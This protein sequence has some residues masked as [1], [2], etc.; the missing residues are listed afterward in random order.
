MSAVLTRR[1]FLASALAG[2]AAATFGRRAWGVSVSISPRP[3][4]ATPRRVAIVGAGL[5]GLTAALD[6]SDAGWDVVVLEARPRVGGRVHTLY[7]PFSTG[8]HAEAGG[9]S[10]DDNHDQIQ[11]LVARFGLRTERRPPDKLLDARVYYRRKR[12][13]LREF[14]G[15]RQGAV[16]L[17]YLRFSDALATLSQDIDP[18][19]PER[20]PNADELD[21]RTLDDFIRSQHLVPE[22]EFLVRLQNRASYNAEPSHLSLLFVAQQTVV[23]ADVP[24]SASETMRIS[25]GNSRLPEAMARALGPRVRLNSPVTRVEH[26]PDGVRV[27]AGGR[28]VDAA[29]LVLAAPMHPLR[30]IIFEPALPASVAAVIEGLELG[31]AA[32]VIHQ[33]STRFWEAEGGSGF[34]VTDLPFAV[35][36]APTDSYPS[37]EGLSPSSSLGTQRGPLL[38]YLTRSGS[39]CSSA[40]S[41]GCTQRESHIAPRTPR[42]LPGRTSATRAVATRCTAPDR[43]YPS[44]PSSGTGWIGSSSRASMPTCSRASWRAPFAAGTASLGSSVLHRE[45]SAALMHIRPGRQPGR[46]P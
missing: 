31:P 30:R 16:L 22:A 35:A 6:L 24:D 38:V 46:A 26:H 1:A 2:A 11:A 39:P 41:I 20:A 7:T 37:V 18:E 8:L 15:R 28:P 34:A 27:F 42:P 33:Y 17:D 3:D 14:L 29:Y 9:E 19:H 36:W 5:A 45:L 21:R 25:G 23:V 32:K 4:P 10:I 13:V 12:S 43:W 40:S 44:G